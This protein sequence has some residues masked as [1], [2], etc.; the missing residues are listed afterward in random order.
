MPKG[1]RKDG[2]LIGILNFNSLQCEITAQ[3]KNNQCFYRQRNQLGLP[4]WWT[5]D[6]DGNKSRLVTEKYGET[7]F[8]DVRITHTTNCMAAYCMDAIL[9]V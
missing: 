1:K 6:P 9:E 8:P 5:A 2:S 3:C 7:I 4:V